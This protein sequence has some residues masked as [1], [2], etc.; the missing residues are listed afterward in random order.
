[1]NILLLAAT[2]LELSFLCAELNLDI[3]T[4]NHIHT[5]Q[6][7]ILISG[8]GM[9]AT[10]Y[11]LS[12]ALNTKKYDLVI[13]AGIAGSF[14][15]EIP[16]GE[17]LKIQSD[18]FAETGAEDGDNFLSLIQLGLMETEE[19]PYRWGELTPGFPSLNSKTFNELNAVRAITVNKVHGNTDSIL[20]IQK[21]LNPQLESMEG[22]ACFYTCMLEGVGCIQIRSVSN[23]VERRNVAA[24]NIPLAV[25]T[26][27]EKLARILREICV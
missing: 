25:K 20:Q 5:H 18:L 14:D 3:H 26:L 4:S 10:T 27:N 11:H 17:T 24:W 16:I 22:A 23:Y 1:M 19:F 12:K 15:R 7:D 21:R 9:V 8:V 2:G 6:I 13:N